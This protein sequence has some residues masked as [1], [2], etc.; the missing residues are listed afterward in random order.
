MAGEMSS[1][2]KNKKLRLKRL[3]AEAL[4][5]EARKQSKIIKSSEIEIEKLN[6]TFI[7]L[8]KKCASLREKHSLAQEKIRVA[9]SERVAEN[10][11]AK[12]LEKKDSAQQNLSVLLFVVMGILYFLFDVPGVL[13][14]VIFFLVSAP[15]LGMV[16]IFFSGVPSSLQEV[17]REVLSSPDAALS[18]LIKN[19]LTARAAVSLMQEEIEK[20]PKDNLLRRKIAVAKNELTLIAEAKKAARKRERSAR[21]ASYEGNA[22]LGSQALKKQL[23]SE[24]KS[25]SKVCSY[26]GARTLKTDLVLDHIHPVAKGGQT[27]LQNSILIC[28]PCNS[29]KRALTLRGFC[30]KAGLDH[31]TVAARLERQG[32]WV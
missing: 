13:V 30:I 19:E 6:S 20:L 12:K 9:V 28:Q 26:C 8:Q 1:E 17:E 2:L 32:K 16:A 15:L 27:V 7:E 22:R 18:R 29:S 14:L 23:L 4:E 21:L 10:S 3:T 25:A 5:E 11:G 24:V 31:E